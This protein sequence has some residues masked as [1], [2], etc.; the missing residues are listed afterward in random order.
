MDNGK[1]TAT[2]YSCPLERKLDNINDD[3]DILRIN[4]LLYYAIKAR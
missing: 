3:S 2:G 1:K 4:C